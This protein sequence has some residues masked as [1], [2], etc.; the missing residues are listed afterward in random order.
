MDTP[1]SSDVA[2][3]HFVVDMLARVEIH[4]KLTSNVLLLLGRWGECEMACL[5]KLWSVKVMFVAIQVIIYH[6]PEKCL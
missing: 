4:N 1:P 5:L 2:V 6:S 3:C